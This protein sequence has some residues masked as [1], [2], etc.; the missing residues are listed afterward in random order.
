MGQVWPGYTVRYPLFSLNPGHCAVDD[1]RRWVYPTGVPRL[2]PEKH[3]KMVD[4]VPAKLE[5]SWDRVLGY[6]VRHE[7]GKLVLRWILVGF[8]LAIS[9]RVS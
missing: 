1:S 7:R 4:A 5:L 3:T 6:L 9:F 8:P 2:V